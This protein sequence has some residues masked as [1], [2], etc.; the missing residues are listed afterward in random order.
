M[1][2]FPLLFAADGS[3]EE[4]EEE[5]EEEAIYGGWKKAKAWRGILEGESVSAAAID[6]YWLEMKMDHTWS[7]YILKYKKIRKKVNWNGA[8]SWRSCVKFQEAK[9][10]MP[11]IIMGGNDDSLKFSREYLPFIASTPPLGER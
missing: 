5:E 1:N 7:N 4:E 11:D 9:P 3:S 6:H 8:S 10:S 2:G